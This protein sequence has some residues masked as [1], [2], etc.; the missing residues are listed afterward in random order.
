MENVFKAFNITAR[1]FDINDKLIC[2]PDPPDYHKHTKGF[3]VLIKNN[4]IY[5]IKRDLK[6]IKRTMNASHCLANAKSSLSHCQANTNTVQSNYYINDREE[7]PECHMIEAAGDL[8]KYTEK[9]EYNL[10]H[11]DND[12]G[13]LF[14]ELRM[15]GCEPF[16]QYQAGT[17]TELKVNS[18][19]RRTRQEITYTIKLQHLSTHSIDEDVSVENE[20]LF[21]KMSREMFN[22]NKKIFNEAHQSFFSQTD[23]NI[24]DESRTILPTRYFKHDFSNRTIEIDRTKAFTKAFSNIA[25]IPVFT[26]FHMW[27]PYRS[28]ELQELNLYLVEASS[29]NIFFN[30]KLNLAYG[31]CLS[32]KRFEETTLKYTTAGNHHTFTKWITKI[33]CLNFGIPT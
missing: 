10:V 22:F 8:S 31:M 33:S 24:L 19:I 27:K 14:H 16:I 4:H 6:I 21:N 20:E 5:T 7:P 18:K 12:L 2:F 25:K 32:L 3:F 26:E 13:K 9:P 29:A 23:I 15:A 28:S 30:K 11:K 1:L 17:M